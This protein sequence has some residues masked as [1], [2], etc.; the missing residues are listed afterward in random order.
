MKH[1]GCCGAL[2]HPNRSVRT[3]LQI[4]E[5]IGATIM[6]TRK[7]RVSKTSKTTKKV[8]TKRSPRTILAD[9]AKIKIVGDHNRRK[10]SRYGGGYEQM[11]KARTVGAF[12]ALRKKLKF[13]DG[14]ELL[15]AA[16]KDEYIKLSA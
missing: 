13:N 14:P 7:K 16:K 1:S 10:D 3:A 9:N 15:R 11:K 8:A 5:S 4:D 12:K 2:H 6:A